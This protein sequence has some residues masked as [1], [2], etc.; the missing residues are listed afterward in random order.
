MVYPI[1]YRVSTIQGGAGFLPSTV[2]RDGSTLIERFV[3]SS[4]YDW[5]GDRRKEWHNHILLKKVTKDFSI[6]LGSDDQPG[7]STT[8]KT[9]LSGPTTPH[10]PSQDQV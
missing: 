4:F 6:F 3:K 5:C 7:V 9:W 8:L 1:I 2:V 10:V